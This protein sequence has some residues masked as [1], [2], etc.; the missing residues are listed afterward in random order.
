[1]TRLVINFC[2]TA[3]VQIDFCAMLKCPVALREFGSS[4]SRRR[5]TLR[6]PIS[7]INILDAS[8]VKY[9]RSDRERRVMPGTGRT[10]HAAQ[11][12]HQP[13]DV[14]VSMREHDVLDMEQIHRVDETYFQAPDPDVVS[15]GASTAH[16]ESTLQSHQ[17]PHSSTRRHDDHVNIGTVVLQLSSAVRLRM[18]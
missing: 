10:A 4:T 9:S 17:S 6:Q 11:G 15:D 14:P 12:R 18:D 3:F 8:L 1:M 2:F 16:H 5:S 13:V 7:R